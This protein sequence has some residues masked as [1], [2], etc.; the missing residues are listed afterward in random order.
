MLMRISTVLIV[1][2]LVGSLALH[3]M[4]GL[5]HVLLLFGLALIGMHFLGDKR[6]AV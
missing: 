4:L 3:I 5:F 6:A 2:W 1:L